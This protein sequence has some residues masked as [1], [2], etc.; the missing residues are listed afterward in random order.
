[1]VIGI[2]S[3]YILHFFLVLCLILAGSFVVYFGRLIV[4]SEY[5]FFPTFFYG[6][7]SSLLQRDRA[8]WLMSPKDTLIDTVAENILDRL[9]VVKF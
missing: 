6:N 8:A 4:V 1:M 7:A 3:L 2:T 5:V 9:E